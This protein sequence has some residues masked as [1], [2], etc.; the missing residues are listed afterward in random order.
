MKEAVVATLL[1]LFIDCACGLL[2]VW[3]FGRK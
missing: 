2:L 3:L 1:M